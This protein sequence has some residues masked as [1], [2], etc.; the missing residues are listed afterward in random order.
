MQTFT[1]RGIPEDRLKRPLQNAGKQKDMP[2]YSCNSVNEMLSLYLSCNYFLSA[3]NVT[4]VT[5]GLSVKTPYP[6][7]FDPFVGSDG[8][9]NSTP[10][11][12]HLSKFKKINKHK[13]N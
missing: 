5:K 1:L 8:N 12:E 7:I 4:A 6:S 11:P 3:T 2:A 13:K 10:R 9:I